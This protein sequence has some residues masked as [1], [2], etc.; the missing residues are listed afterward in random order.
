MPRPISAVMYASSTIEGSFRSGN[1][2]WL[3]MH[4]SNAPRSF[5]LIMGGRPYVVLALICRQ[6]I[7]H[8]VR[9]L[10]SMS[11]LHRQL[12]FLLAC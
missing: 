4:E 3:S 10:T 11:I 1:E 9:F 12:V 6:Y 2:Q 7:A 5:K 8:M